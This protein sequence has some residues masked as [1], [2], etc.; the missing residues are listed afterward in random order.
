VLL[1]LDSSRLSEMQWLPLESNPDVL[2]AVKV[3]TMMMSL[4]VIRA[5]FFDD[6]RFHFQLC[7]LFFFFL[8]TALLILYIIIVC[9]KNWSQ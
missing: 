8:N 5:L 9:S 1:S 7:S 2:N 3:S 4:A 6:L